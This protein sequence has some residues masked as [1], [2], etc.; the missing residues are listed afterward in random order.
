MLQLVSYLVEGWNRWVY[1]VSAF[2][3]NLTDCRYCTGTLMSIHFITSVFYRHMYILFIKFLSQVKSLWYTPNNIFR[4]LFKVNHKFKIRVFWDIVP[5]SL[6][7][8]DRRFGVAYC[9][10]HQGDE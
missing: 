5:C 6:V 9:L 7:G 8:V 1:L 3:S 4:P 10:H 2:T